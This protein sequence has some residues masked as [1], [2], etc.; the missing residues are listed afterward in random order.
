MKPNPAQT[1]QAGGLQGHRMQL[2]LPGAAFETTPAIPN[3][4]RRETTQGCG[5][6]RWCPTQL[7]QMRLHQFY[8]GGG[9]SLPISRVHLV[10]GLLSS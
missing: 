2:K 5:C 8:A 10:I 7:H 3:S 9:K 6:S 4:V 1:R